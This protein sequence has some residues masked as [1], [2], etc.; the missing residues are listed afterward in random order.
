MV[1]EDVPVTR[2]VGQVADMVNNL[3]EDRAQEI[4]DRYWKRA[5]G[6]TS[7]SERGYRSFWD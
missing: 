5:L 3:T 7:L 4:E 2:M 6:T 1:D